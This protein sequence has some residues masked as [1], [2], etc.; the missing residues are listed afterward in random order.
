MTFP[1]GFQAGIMVIDSNTMWYAVSEM[2]DDSTFH[3]AVPNGTYTVIGG[4]QSPTDTL[5]H[6]VQNVVVLDND[7]VVNFY[8][9]GGVIVPII[10]T[11]IANNLVFN[12]K[13]YPNPFRGVGNIAFTTPVDGKA[14]LRI[15][16]LNGRML[17]IL[18][19]GA[20]SKGKYAV[21]FTTREFDYPLGAGYY[22][23]RIDIKGEK[24]YTKNLRIINIK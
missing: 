21:Q 22:I 6:V 11:P 1:D 15:Y 5:Y 9:T 10:Y 2:E 16:D 23:A 19:N 12:M 17:K 4:Y 18:Y 8:D 20:V 7:M 14:T 3:F 13:C 24:R